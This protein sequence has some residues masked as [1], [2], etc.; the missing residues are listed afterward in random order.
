MLLQMPVS[1]IL[2]HRHL[3]YFKTTKTFIELTSNMIY[4]VALGIGFKCPRKIHLNTQCPPGFSDLATGLQF[5]SARPTI[6]LQ[7]TIKLHV[8][9]PYALIIYVWSVKL[10]LISP[11]VR[12]PSEPGAGGIAPP[13]FVRNRS[14]TCSIKWPFITSWPPSPQ[15]F[16]PS[17]GPDGYWSEASIQNQFGWVSSFYLS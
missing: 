10:D 8:P 9:W 12:R 5:I 6:T 2:A 13:D 17:Y 15:I 3:W 11:L 16:R 4:T 14:E 7:I 1:K